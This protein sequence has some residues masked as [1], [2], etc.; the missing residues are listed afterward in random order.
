MKNSSIKK[1][2]SLFIEKKQNIFNI[3]NNIFVD[4]KNNYIFAVLK[5]MRLLK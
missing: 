3:F 5:N 4:E 2:F 1:P